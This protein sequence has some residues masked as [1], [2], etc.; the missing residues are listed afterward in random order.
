MRLGLIAR[1][2]PTAPGAYAHLTRYM[3]ADRIRI[4]RPELDLHLD[5]RQQAAANRPCS[6]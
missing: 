6:S 3:M 2:F 4:L 5:P 1:D